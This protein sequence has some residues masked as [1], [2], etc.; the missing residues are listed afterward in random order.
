MQGDGARA[1]IYCTTIADSTIAKPTINAQTLNGESECP[2]SNVSSLII[3]LGAQLGFWDQYSN[4]CQ[5][6]YRVLVMASRMEYWPNERRS[7]AANET[8]I[9][10]IQ[11][12]IHTH[13]SEHGRFHLILQIRSQQFPLPVPLQR[14]LIAEVSR[15]HLRR[16]AQPTQYHHMPTSRAR[17]D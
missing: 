13:R 5:E 4:Q 8:L 11:T 10:R 1:P 17:E 12:V 9:L 7:V 15:G 16:T 6:A 3:I 14:R 2:T